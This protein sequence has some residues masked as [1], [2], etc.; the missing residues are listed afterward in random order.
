MD[1]PTYGPTKHLQS[2]VAQLKTYHDLK[3]WTHLRVLLSRLGFF[4]SIN[5]SWTHLVMFWS[6]GYFFVTDQ[7]VCSD[8][9]G[10]LFISGCVDTFGC[11]DILRSLGRF[12]SLGQSTKTTFVSILY[13]LCN[14]YCNLNLH[15][16]IYKCCLLPKML[17][18]PKM[19]QRP[20]ISKQ[21]KMSEQPKLSKRPKSF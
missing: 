13:L 16:I 14:V 11:L 17:E 3:T 5:Q 4:C 21:P 6:L 2:C 15:L 12:W 18:Q 7:S 1:G 19:S 20:K 9:F 8:I 10:L